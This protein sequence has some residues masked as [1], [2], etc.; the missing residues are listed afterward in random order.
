MPA[1]LSH[2]IMGEDLHK[3]SESDEKLFKVS[4]EKESLKANSIGQD[5]SIVSNTLNKY[6]AH[7]FNT[8]LFFMN[9]VK[10]IKDNK[11]Y[12]NECVMSLLYGQIA[13]YF[14]DVNTHPLIYYI[15]AGCKSP[16]AISS[17]M[18]V[19]GYLSSY[20]AEKILGKDYMSLKGSYLGHLDLTDKDVQDL[21]KWVYM[22]TYGDKQALFSYKS[23]FSVLKF[24]EDITKNPHLSSKEKLIK[25]SKFREFLEM[26][27]LSLGEI[28]NDSNAT[29]TNPQTNERH[30]ESFMELYDKSITESQEAI[31]KVNGFI[32]DG[33]S[34]DTL[35]SVFT[36]LSFDTGVS[37]SLGKDLKYVRKI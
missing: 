15:E 37:C 23:E 9:L 16:N 17:H 25:V 32:Y 3:K 4:V 11:L 30:S 29:W 19:E 28:T 14:L 26:N 5:L 27:K 2:A 31:S 35:N 36:D 22:K 7:N 18:L 1:Y 24:V 12:E 10:C 33:N 20:M 13:H 6:D 8:K 21:V 34:I